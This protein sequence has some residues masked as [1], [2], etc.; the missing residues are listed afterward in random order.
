M[1][2]IGRIQ[3]IS[4]LQEA[5]QSERA[6]MLAVYGRRRVGK[7]FLIKKVYG[8]ELCFSMSGIHN[9][10]LKEQLQ[11]FS[12]ALKEAYGTRLEIKPP[13]NW[14]EAFELL[15]NYLSEPIKQETTGRLRKGKKVIFFDE[16]P[17]MDT[18]KSNFLQS[19]DHFW[20]SWAAHRDDI[21]F[22]ICGSAASWMI[23]K[24]VHNKGGLHNRVTKRIRLLPFT[25]AETELFF[26]HKQ[27][28]LD[29]YSMAQLYM[30]IGGIPFYLNEVKRGESVAQNIDRICFTKDG[31]LQHEFSNLYKSLFNNSD[32]HV[33]IIKALAGSQRGLSRSEIIHKTKMKTGGAVTELFDELLES[34]FISEI[35]A[36]QKKGKDHIYRL[37]DEYSLFYIKFIEP[38]KVGGKNMWMQLSSKPSYT[39]WCGYAFEN[40]CFK[41]VGAIL[42]AL[43][44][45]GIASHINS[46]QHRDA[47][48]DL[49]IDR[50]DRSVNICE[51]KF[52][53]GEFEITKTYA[54]KLQQKIEVY[55]KVQA[56]RKNL[57]LTLV[58]TF[59]VKENMYRNSMVDQ[60]IVL[61]QLF[62]NYT[63]R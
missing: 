56:I 61:D 42:K 52:Y 39:S 5:L 57:F 20:N 18:P 12:N 62:E 30:A 33:K 53:A 26:Q 8:N 37:T 29:R 11:N 21:V 1:E 23:K 36:Q 46:W 63:I 58:T 6:E 13:S 16:L 41:H 35:Q 44:I 27:I 60:V 28:K 4:I 32:K 48:I 45:S 51:M 47:Q 10:S 34:G 15:K 54:E 50:Q 7:T 19:L 17:W 24:I 55:R 22:V 38:N 49:L 3:E 14:V 43:G 9:A 25:L 59:G 31:L 2:L 40:L